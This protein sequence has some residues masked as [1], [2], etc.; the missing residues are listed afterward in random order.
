MFNFPIEKYKFIVVN[1]ANGEPYKVIALSTYAG[2][3]VRGVATCSEKDKFDLEVGKKLAA[4]RCNSKVAEKRYKRAAEC[5]TYSQQYLEYAT[6]VA[7]ENET[8]FENSFSALQKAASDLLK[9]EK[10]C[11]LYEELV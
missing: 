3:T 5:H 1:H 7:K 10:S 2:K 8:Y 11:G 9:L 6:A 4:A